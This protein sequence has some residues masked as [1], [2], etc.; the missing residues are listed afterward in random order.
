MEINEMLNQVIDRLKAAN[1]YKIVLF[2]SQARGTVTDE[3]DIDLM[4]I[5]DDNYISKNCQEYLDRRRI[6]DDLLLD[7]IIKSEWDMD[8]KV[9]SMAEFWQLKERES[10]FIKEVE[11]TG[12]TIYEKRN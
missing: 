12:K 9:Y 6:V 11:R 4:V 10:F 1:P 5:L 2:G 7:L 8:I 3:S